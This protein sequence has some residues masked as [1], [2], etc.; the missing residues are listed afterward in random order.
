[1]IDTHAHIDTSAF[2]E[3]RDSII[4]RAFES[5]VD[6]IIIPGIEPK[7]FDNIITLT[8]KY[9]QIF[10]GIGIHPHYAQQVNSETLAQI[11]TLSMNPKVIAIGEIGLD[12]F[13][14]FAPKDIQKEAFSNQIKLAKSLDKPVIVHNRDSDEDLLK[15]L[16]YEQ[17]G[18]LQGVLHCFSGDNITLHKALEMG[19][20]VSFTGNITFKKS[21]LNEIVQMAPIERILLETDS[22][23]MT[24]VPHR[25]KRNEPLFVNYIA[26]KISDIKSIPIE[27]VIK[28]TTAN[29]KRL[30][31]LTI[32]LLLVPILTLFSQNYESDTAQKIPKTYQFEKAFGIG[33]VIGTHTIVQTIY[34]NTLTP[35]LEKEVSYEGIFFYGAAVNYSLYDFLLLEAVYTYAKNNKIIEKSKDLEGPHIYQ[36]IEIS[37]I[38]TANPYSKINFYAT[39][40]YSI[41]SNTLNQG[42]DIEISQSSNGFNFGLGLRVNIPVKNIGLF[43]PY[44]EWRI[45]WAPTKVS[46]PA[47]WNPSDTNPTTVGSTSY[48]SMPRFGI[49]FYPDFLKKYHF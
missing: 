6:S 37:S 17:D 29:A 11:E 9:E 12:Y 39:L 38:W 20:H 2:D 7:D 43:T 42:R 48:Y 5:G 21:M 10:C 36:I 27:E 1:M 49:T 46:G 26:E 33:G 28:M 8:D 3:D 14:D 23:Y 34:N 24:P 19:F 15:I 47:Y 41:Y 18:T 16:E 32:F 25:G 13:Y 35:N 45:N 22:P 40:G 4:K 30:F 44:I 31:R